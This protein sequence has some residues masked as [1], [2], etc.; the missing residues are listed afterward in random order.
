MK[1]KS[2]ESTDFP[3]EAKFE[4]NVYREKL[5]ILKQITYTK[6]RL[7]KHASSS[8]QDYKTN[9]SKAD[10]EQGIFIRRHV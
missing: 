9:T 5:E 8:L 2:Q 6:T 4:S 7:S 1:F 10:F 3:T